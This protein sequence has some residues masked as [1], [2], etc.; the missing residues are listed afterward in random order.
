MSI[1][2]GGRLCPVDSGVW[3]AALVVSGCADNQWG[4]ESCQFIEDESVEVGGVY[5]GSWVLRCYD[6]WTG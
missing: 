3:E 6:R 2:A 1:T 5:V 4:E